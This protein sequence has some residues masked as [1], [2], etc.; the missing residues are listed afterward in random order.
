MLRKLCNKDKTNFNCFV[1][2]YNVS[3]KLFSKFVRQEQLA[4]VSEENETING[5]IFVEKNDKS[6]I[7]ICSK[8]IQVTNNLL[9]IFFWNWK[10]EIHAKINEKDKTG[11][12]LKKNGFRIIGKIDKDFILYYNPTETRKSWKK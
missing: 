8:S 9:K 7:N 12:L 3:N 1:S 11:F 6:Y 10:K 4:F 5:L 2:D